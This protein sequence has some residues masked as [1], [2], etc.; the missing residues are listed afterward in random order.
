MAANRM[1][2][3]ERI[4]ATIA[5]EEVDR[6]AIALWRHF[7]VDDQSP[8]SLAEATIS[9]QR[10]Y[11]FDLVKVT[12]ASSFCVR[13]WGAQ[14]EWRGASEGTREYTH[15]VIQEPEDW[16]DLTL[17]DPMR[18]SLGGQ[19]ECL[20]LIVEEIGQDVPVIQTI[21]SPLAQAKN[22]VGA[23][24]LFVHLRRYPHHLKAGLDVITKSIQQF[25]EEAMRIGI[26]G[27][28]YAVQHAQYGLLSEREYDEFGRSFDLAAL[29]SSMELQF[30]MLHLHGE[31][32]MFD[33][34]LNYPVSIIN[35]HDR[36]SPPSLAE[37]REKFSGALCGGLRRQETMVL[38]SPDGVR[39][40]TYDAIQQTDGKGLIL[41]TGCVM[42][43]IVPR[44]NIIAARK[45]V[46]L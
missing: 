19:L 42:P 12:P 46:E 17:L 20:R 27:V 22:L 18:G 23:D 40:E 13:D 30:N 4:A 25:I 31:Q 3:Y 44:G 28:F 43:T 1:N 2:H 9:F 32:V 5:R 41:G 6:P 33:R 34:F 45:C 8:G 24:K 37:A 29:E 36:E 11:D 35:W 21:F 39:E 16:E 14:D 15:R 7:P 26:S 38:G 10:D